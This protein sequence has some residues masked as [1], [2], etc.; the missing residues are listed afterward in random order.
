M[1]AVFAL[2]LEP[3]RMVVG[4]GGVNSK[5]PCWGLAAFMP[6]STADGGKCRD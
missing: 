4:K 5:H 1:V 6:D 3:M 2:V